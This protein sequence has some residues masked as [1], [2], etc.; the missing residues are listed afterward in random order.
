MLPNA[1][2]VSAFPSSAKVLAFCSN[3]FPR[4]PVK[5]KNFTT[6][7][8]YLSLVIDALTALRKTVQGSSSDPSITI[9]FLNIFVHLINFET[10]IKAVISERARR[11]RDEQL[12]EDLAGISMKHRDLANLSLSS[13]IFRTSPIRQF[14]YV[15]DLNGM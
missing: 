1:Q 14:P 7:V 9:V 6:R 15:Y 8:L 10:H 2:F 5:S 13:V 11:M 3:V 4:I 12:F